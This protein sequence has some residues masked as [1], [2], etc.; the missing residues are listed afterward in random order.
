MAAVCASEQ[1]EA[2]DE[3]DALAVTDA[4]IDASAAIAREVATQLDSEEQATAQPPDGEVDVDATMAGVDAMWE[5]M[6]LREPPRAAPPASPAIRPPPP[7]ASRDEV[8]AYRAAIR[9]AAVDN[10]GRTRAVVAAETRRLAQ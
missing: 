10:I 6:K 2:V 7:G 3:A 1:V 8:R 5:R 4:T 9:A